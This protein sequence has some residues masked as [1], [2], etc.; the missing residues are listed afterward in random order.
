MPKVYNQ[1]K[2]P[3]VGAVY[4]GRGSPWGNPYVIGKHGTRDE[5]CDSFESMAKQRPEFLA[6][7]RRE[8]KGKDLVCFCAPKRCHGD[9]LLRI[10]NDEDANR[11]S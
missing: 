1:Y 11:D 2:N 8:L 9:F 7:V 4:I 5:V 3:P 10:A 6:Q